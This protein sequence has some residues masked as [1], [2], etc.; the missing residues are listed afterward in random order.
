MGR[1][2]HDIQRASGLFPEMDLL[3]YVLGHD[4]FLFGTVLS[5]QLLPLCIDLYK[6]LFSKAAVFEQ[7][8]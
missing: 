2:L 4:H 8:K 3:T 6:K 5:C 1:T 7:N